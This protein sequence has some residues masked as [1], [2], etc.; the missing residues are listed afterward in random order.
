MW[1]KV[2]SKKAE[3]FI[4]KSA[5][6]TISSLESDDKPDLETK[7]KNTQKTIQII[8]GLD[9]KLSEKLSEQF[10]EITTNKAKT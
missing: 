7:I 9:E 8:A 6:L 3:T 4:T 1:W 2:N 10:I 5:Q